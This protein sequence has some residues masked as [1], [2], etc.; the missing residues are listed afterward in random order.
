MALH[1]LEKTSSSSKD[2]A[3]FVTTESANDI[4][5]ADTTPEFYDPS[6]ES[7][8]TRLGVNWESFKRAPGTTGCVFAVFRCQTLADL[9]KRRGLAIHGENA[10]PLKARENPMLCVPA[11]SSSQRSLNWIP[12]QSAEDETAAPGTPCA[13]FPLLNFSLTRSVQQQMIAVGGSCV[14]PAAVGRNI[15]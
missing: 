8:A 3:G 15:D 12:S 10:D 7:R 11:V 6:K 14:P 9:R 13:A 2:E 1:D 4:E 5:R